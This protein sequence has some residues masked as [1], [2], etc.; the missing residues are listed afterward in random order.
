MCGH[1]LASKIQ[2]NSTTS[3]DMV[4]P[5]SSIPHALGM[6]Y[7]HMTLAVGA[8]VVVASYSSTDVLMPLLLKAHPS[9]VFM[10]PYFLL[11]LIHNTKVQQAGFSSIQ[12]LNSGD[13]KV[14][15]LLQKE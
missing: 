9:I 15:G 7:S 1:S 2:V 3:Q 14:A 4:M 8:Q 10:L 13:N 5:T 12:L 11:M 6:N